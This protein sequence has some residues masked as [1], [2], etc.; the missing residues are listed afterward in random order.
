MLPV[1]QFQHFIKSQDL[2]TVESKV[3]LAL[4]GG[5]D[6]VLMA[7][8]FKLAGYQFGIAHCNFGLRGSESVRDEAFVRDLSLQMEVPFHHV[9]FDTLAYAAKLKISTQMAARDLRYEWFDQIRKELEY[10]FI[11]LAHH[12][13]DVIETLLLNLTRGTGIAGMHGILP[14]RGHFIRPLLFLNRPQIDA[15]I[16]D[17]QI[18]FVEDSSNTKDSYARNRLRLNVIPE[19]KLINQ[20]LEKTFLQNVRRFAE[21]EMVL[22]QQVETLR[23]RLMIYSVNDPSFVAKIAIEDLKSLVPQRLL[24]FEL[25]R[26]YG[27]TE[28]VI[29]DVIRDLGHQSGTSF[30]SEQYRLTINRQSLILTLNTEKPQHQVLIHEDCTEVDFDQQKLLISHCDGN[31]YKKSPGFAYVD[32]ELLQ[33][34]LMLRTRIAGDR[35]IPLGMTT[36]KKLSNYF[37]DQK[38]PLPEKDLVPLLINGNGAL[39]WVIGMR[40][41]NRY[42]V[43]TTTKKVAIFELKLK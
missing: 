13:N 12:Q 34:P 30:Y 15:L 7:H 21:T 39:I 16:M 40:Q 35:F 24:L 31:E 17:H 8:L 26:I 1:A 27:F 11:A 14:K 20:G 29:D 25:L 6:S 43:K 28:P 42:K 32:A 22:Q 18:D 36:F 3:L 19:L 23:S 9:R 33:Y 2:F 41:D 5:K 38:V 4:S 37:V 10:D